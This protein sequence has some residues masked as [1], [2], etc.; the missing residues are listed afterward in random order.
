MV[1]WGPNEDS[2]IIEDTQK[3]T[4]VLPVYF[5]TKNF[6]SFVR[7]L[8]MYGFHKIKNDRSIHEFRHPSFRKGHYD[9]LAHI[10]RKNITN[11]KG[12]ENIDK[13][14]DTDEY[15]K[16]RETLERTKASLETITQQN[17]NLIAANKEVAS[18]L[19][20]FKH[21]YESR[22]KKLFFMFYF[23]INSKDEKLL[24]LL[25][26]TLIE[27]G[28]AF[29]GDKNKNYEEQ[30][31]EVIGHINRKILVSSSSEQIVISKL[32]NTFTEYITSNEYFSEGFNLRPLEKGVD[33]R[34][35]I[36]DEAGFEFQYVNSPRK[37]I[38]SLNINLKS[39]T[40]SECDFSGNNS[41]MLQKSP[42]IRFDMF[43]IR[44]KNT[45]FDL[46]RLMVP[47]TDV[48]GSENDKLSKFPQSFKKRPIYDI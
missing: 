3:F 41:I 23:L 13:E 27:L 30:T 35:D 11:Q 36:N 12:D 6:A 9:D 33:D 45:E 5:K 31:S 18:K 2:F 42:I 10:K 46:E 16:L 20:N 8:N 39:E 14:L 34:Q 25:K 29:D 48:D 17:I 44:N 26:K 28:V 19:Y 1:K 22:L 21:D 15:N 40:I 43:E 24:N 38:Q 4:K 47:I 7:Q 37:S 32:L